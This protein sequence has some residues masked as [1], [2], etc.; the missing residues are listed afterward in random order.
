MSK[1]GGGSSRNQILH[2][3]IIAESGS[4]SVGIKD[5]FNGPGQAG[6]NVSGNRVVA[7][8]CSKDVGI[9]GVGNT[10]T[11]PDEG[12]SWGGAIAR[13]AMALALLFNF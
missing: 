9:Q 4:E 7:R 13:P 8:E 3:E 11:R 6:F 12:S 1:G 2:N 10:N 5:S